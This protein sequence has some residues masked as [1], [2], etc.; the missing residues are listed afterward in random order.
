MTLYDLFEGVRKSPS[1]YGGGAPSMSAQRMTAPMVTTVDRTAPWVKAAI[2]KARKKTQDFNALATVKEKF[3]FIYK[4][5]STSTQIRIPSQ[6]RNP[7]HIQS[8]DPATGAI[9]LLLKTPQ[10]N[11]IV[12]GNAND[13]TY[14]GRQVTPST[15]GK[16]YIF[17]PGKVTAVSTE[18]RQAVR[19]RPAG[20]AKKKYDF[21][22]M[23]W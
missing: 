1:Q 23:P 4:L 3:D 16:T 5:Q 20:P 11:E 2:G 12:A 21:P 17:Q 22:K 7:Y 13:F 9:S 19:G 6:G 8:Y 10:G 15:G 18:P 14:Q